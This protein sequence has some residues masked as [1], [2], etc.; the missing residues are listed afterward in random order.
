MFIIRDNEL[1]HYNTQRVPSFSDAFDSAGIDGQHLS[2]LRFEDDLR[3]SGIKIQDNLSGLP[4]YK[5]H[6]TPVSVIRF[7]CRKLQHVFLLGTYLLR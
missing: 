3:A 6:R 4:R 1:V 5:T 7:V 2:P